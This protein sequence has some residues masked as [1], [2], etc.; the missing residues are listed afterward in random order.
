MLVAEEVGAREVGGQLP[1]RVLAAQGVGGLGLAAGLGAL[2]LLVQQRGEAVFVD[3]Q[4]GVAGG[5][6]GQLQGEA[7]GVGE[8]EGGLARQGAGAALAG[9]GDRGVQEPGALR[10]GTGEGLFLGGDDLLDEVG[11]VG[12]F[13]PD[14]AE[15]GDHAGG[16]RREDGLVDAE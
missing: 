15:V 9:A 8:F 6:D 2:L 5:L 13:G 10:E 12:E 11:L 7:E 3:G 16:G 4:A 14:V 1:V